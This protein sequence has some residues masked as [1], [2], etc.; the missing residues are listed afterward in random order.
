MISAKFLV[1]VVLVTLAATAIVL[2]M[3]PSSTDYAISNPRWNGL[4]AAS[5]QLGLSGLTSLRR[6][7]PGPGTVL[8]VIPSSLPSDEEGALLKAFLTAGGTLVV[9]DDFGRNSF[10]ERLGVGAR[11]DGKALADGLFNYKNMRLPRITDIM[12]SP[13]TD[14]VDQLVLNHATVI[15]PLGDL[16]AVATSSPVSFLDA[17]GNGRH[18][19]GEAPGPFPVVALGRVGSGSLVL[20]ADSSLLLNSMLGLGH[21]RRLAKNIFRLAGEHP[22]I[23]L[24]E[25]HLPHEPLDAAKA[26]LGIVRGTL[27]SPLVAFAMVAVILALPLM[28]LLRPAR[29]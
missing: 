18:D 13:I 11:F 27:A 7:P 28:S 15:S 22:R 24:D 6:L 26:Y 8:V 12:P 16:R 21:N 5:R 2:W 9:M 10:L 17:N 4:Q 29:R 23:L 14:R 19:A 1:T 20:V 25:A 3:Y